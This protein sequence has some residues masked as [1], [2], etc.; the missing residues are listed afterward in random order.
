MGAVIFIAALL[1]IPSQVLAQEKV[2]STI[3]ANVEAMP[4][5]EQVLNGTYPD[6]ARCVTDGEMA[7]CVGLVQQ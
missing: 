4:T 3:T 1:L 7:I 2:L 6:N 5:V